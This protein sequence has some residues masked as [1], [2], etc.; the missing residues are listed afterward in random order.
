MQLF[1]NPTI[2]KGT[3]QITFDKV[4]SRHII[5]V[6]RKTMG[7]Q[8]KITNGKG[9]L[10][11]CVISIANDKRCL[12]SIVSREEKKQ[13]REYYLHVVVAPTKNNDRLEWFL[14]K[15]TE[16]GIDEITPIICENSERKFIKAERLEKIIIAAM[17][18]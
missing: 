10:F 7:D 17:K 13:F 8:I 12:V 2:D 6:L 1:Y 16:I 5:K 4:E 9:E 14:E 3:Q 15:A 11:N 18:Q